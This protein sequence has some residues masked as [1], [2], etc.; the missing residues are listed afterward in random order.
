M[1]MFYLLFFF[2]RFV[3]NKKG[4]MKKMEEIEL[5]EGYSCPMKYKFH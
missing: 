1:V 4:R 3:E 2:L 5:K